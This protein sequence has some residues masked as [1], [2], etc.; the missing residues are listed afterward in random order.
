MG[1]RGL[2]EATDAAGG[3]AELPR[4]IGISRPSVSSWSKVPSE[5][6]LSVEAVMDVARAI[7]WPDPGGDQP[8]EIDD[9]DAARAQEYALLAM[10]LL[11]GPDAAILRRTAK[12]RGDATSLGLAHVALAQAADNASAEKIEREFFNL[13]IGIGRGKALP[14]GSYYLTGLLNER[15]LAR[16]R[17]DLGALGIERA[18][19][20][21]EPEDHAAVLC[22]IMTALTGGQFA[23]AERVQQQ[24]FEKHLAPLDRPL[25]RRSGAGQGGRFLSPCGNGRPAIHRDRD[26]SIRAA[27]VS[28]RV[29]R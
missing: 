10:L 23:V 1:D 3:A 5:R 21:V 2:Q 15:P 20:Q 8:G 12:L 25:L 13:F 27:R 4:G 19:G 22:E 24:F 6:V 26:G 14:Y 11:R 17:A 29:G 18:E 16:L 9:V 7:S 28:G